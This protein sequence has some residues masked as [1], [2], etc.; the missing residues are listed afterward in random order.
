VL[1]HRGGAGGRQCGQGVCT[2]AGALARTRRIFEA[3]SQTDCPA[4]FG[5]VQLDE[6]RRLQHKAE[7]GYSGDHGGDSRPLLR[8]Q[9]ERAQRTGPTCHRAEGSHLWHD[10]STFARASERLKDDPA[11]GEYVKLAVWALKGFEIKS[12]LLAGHKYMINDCLGMK[13]SAGEFALTIPDPD[14]RV[15]SDGMVLTFA[16]PHVAMNAFS[17]RLRPDLTDA[18][19]PCHFSGVVGIA[20][21]ADDVRYEM[22]FDPQLDL[23]QCKIGS[24]GEVHQVWRIGTLRLEPLPAAVTNLAGDMVEDALTAFAN[25]DVTDRIVAV[26]NAAADTQCHK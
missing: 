10:R 5:L 11:I 23:E 19:E 16:I 25:L 22:H 24:M 20:G 18:L 8:R 4:D 14:L 12:A 3:R 13:V 17:V 26:L 9:R 1:R 2:R 7:R 21:A 6:C 15:V